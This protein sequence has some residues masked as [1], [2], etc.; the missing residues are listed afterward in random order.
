MGGW[1]ASP[2]PICHTHMYIT[3]K[4]NLSSASVWYSLMESRHV[5]GE[6]AYLWLQACLR[7]EDEGVGGGVQAHEHALHVGVERRLQERRPTRL[8]R[9]LQRLVAPVQNAGTGG[10]EGG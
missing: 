9:Q 10:V 7:E 4:L 8:Q 5:A 3:V 1:L 6:E 2:E